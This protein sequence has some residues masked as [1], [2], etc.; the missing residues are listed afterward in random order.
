M[1]F[2]VFYILER[3]PEAEGYRYVQG[4]G[5][6]DSDFAGVGHFLLF[7]DKVCVQSA[8][9]NTRCIVVNRARLGFAEFLYSLYVE[10]V[11]EATCLHSAH[12]FAS[13]HGIVI[14]FLNKSWQNYTQ[15]QEWTN[16]SDKQ[17][18]A[19]A[20]RLHGWKICWIIFIGKHLKEG[21]YS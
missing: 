7:S 1:H 14:H 4:S 15:H 16:Q 3:L 12:W 17:L 21:S 10:I 20:D 13:V 6:W 2:Y 18:L 19:E 11:T 9:Q 5:A 8:A